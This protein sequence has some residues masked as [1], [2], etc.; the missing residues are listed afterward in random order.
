MEFFYI[1]NVILLLIL[2]LVLL[3]L[4]YRKKI[5]NKNCKKEGYRSCCWMGCSDNCTK[6]NVS[7]KDTVSYNP[8]IYPS[9]ALSCPKKIS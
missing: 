4:L 9:S 2:V 6:K 1:D 8:F 7:K 3:Y 5:C